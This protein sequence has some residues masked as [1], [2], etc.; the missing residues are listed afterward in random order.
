MFRASRVHLQEDKVVH[1]QHLIFSHSM[2]VLTQALYRQATKNS[3][4]G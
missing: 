3:H 1:T 2:R 4:R